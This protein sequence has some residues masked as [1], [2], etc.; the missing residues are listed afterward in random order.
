MSHAHQSITLALNSHSC[1]SYF[2]DSTLGFFVFLH[3][4]Y[5]SYLFQRRI[6]SGAV[7]SSPPHYS[8]LH[9]HPSSAFAMTRSSVDVDDTAAPFH[10]W[11]SVESQVSTGSWLGFLLPHALLSAHGTESICCLPTPDP[12][13][14]SLMTSAPL[15]HDGV[16]CSQV[17]PLK[18]MTRAHVRR[19]VV[20]LDDVDDD[21]GGIVGIFAGG[22]V[23]M[24]IWRCGWVFEVEPKIYD[25][26]PGFGGSL[27]VVDGL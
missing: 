10:S 27:Y 12:I 13:G 7:S 6:S 2:Q 18:L 21:G 16:A 1:P 5:L 19:L 22:S 9:L 26:E 14:S 11:S 24:V 3:L 4:Y 20:G 23:M 8:L 25:L 17:S 15:L